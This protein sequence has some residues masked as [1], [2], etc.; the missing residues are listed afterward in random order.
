MGSVVILL[1]PPGAGKGTQ[2]KRLSA[3]MELPHVA[4]GDLFRENLSQGTELGTKAKVFMDAGKLVP[5]EFV[6]DML[7]D[8]LGRSDAQG[9]YVL[10]GFP[11]TVP[12]AEALDSRLGDASSK[13][14]RILIDV[15]DD[16]LVE[17][18]VGRRL[19]KNCGNIHHMKYSP[20]K[21]EGVC[22]NCG[23]ELYQRSDDT[24]ET[25]AE[26]LAVYR[27]DTQPVID[28]YEGQGSLRRVDGRVA[29]DE[30]FDALNGCLQEAV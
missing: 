25:V 4:T 17:R 6:L 20:P 26:R 3:A 30:V 28:Y 10:D 23:G 1:G 19:C 9:G 27:R 21:E 5:N 7:F 24:A 18:A 8:R 12:Q 11:R 2:A 16:F 14:V 29:P 13:A 22:D 15:P